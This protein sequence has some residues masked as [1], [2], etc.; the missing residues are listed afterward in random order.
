M[1]HCLIHTEHAENSFAPGGG[2]GTLQKYLP[3][4]Q[5]KSQL[6]IMGKVMTK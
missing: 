4:L 1:V 5:L 6:L 2:A 3:F